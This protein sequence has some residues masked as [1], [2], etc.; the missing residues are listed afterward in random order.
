VGLADWTP[1]G[2]DPSVVRMLGDKSRVE[3]PIGRVLYETTDRIGALRISPKGDHIAIAE[4]PPGLGSGWAVAVLDQ[5]G[6]KKTLTSGWAGDFVDLA[7]SPR[8]DEIWFNTRQ[9][10]DG[11]IH[12]V[13]VSGRERRL[14][15]TAIALQLFD[16]GRDGRALVGS[17]HWR[18]GIMGVPPGETEERD[19]SWLDASEVDDVAYD[20]KTLLITEYGDGGGVGRGSV[21]LRRLEDGSAVRLGD[22]QGFAISPDARWALALRRTPRP[23]LVVWP[24]SAGDPIFLNNQQITDYT[25]ADWLP[26]GK[27]IVFSG[28]ESGHGTRC[29]VQAIDGGEARAITAEGISLRLGQRAVSPD[30]QWVA[31][32]GLDG[33][34]SLYAISGGNVRTISGANPWDVPIRWSYDERSLFVFRKLESP[35]KIYLIDLSTGTNA[36][37]KPVAPPDLAGITDIWGAHVGP[38]E[39]SYY[40]SFMRTASDLQVVDGLR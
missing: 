7:W 38:D 37:W 6:K 12:A 16:V 27:R 9:G 23:Q 10:G 25:G 39:K 28:T 8:G 33:K 4:R 11:A 20:G 19:L 21:Y 17:V 15:R 32:T 40:Y 31:A 29:Y 3:S 5:N 30:G 35:P 26:D 34:V 22:G 1:H 13:S 14:A 24:I 36:V 18:S 2:S